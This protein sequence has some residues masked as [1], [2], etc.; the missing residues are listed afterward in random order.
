[1]KDLVELKKDEAF[2]TSKIIAEGTGNKHHSITAIIQKYDDDFN[3]F[4]KI[5]FI[6]LKSINPSGGRP[7]KLYYLNEEQATLLMTYLRNN[8]TVRKF[9]K[10]LVRQ[11]YA[12][13]QFIMERQSEDWKAARLNGK[14]TRLQETDILKQL[15]EYAREQG[16]KHADMLYMVYTKLVK[17]YIPNARDELTVHELEMIKLMENIIIQTIRKGM[18]EEKHYKEIYKDCQYRLDQFTDIG[19]LDTIF[20]LPKR[21]TKRLSAKAG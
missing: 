4:G 19:Y 14:V 7:E 1:M 21:H 16:S 5:R 18:A 15:V 17:G 13:R 20:S 3:F 11:F 9:K 6:D 12:M 8:D 2:T 10:E